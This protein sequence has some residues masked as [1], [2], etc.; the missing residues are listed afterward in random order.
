MATAARR[1]DPSLEDIL[2]D[3][4][5]EF[6]FFQ[7]VRLL[8]RVF[9]ERKPVGTTARPEEEVTR[10][11]SR[12]SMA[13]PPSAIHEIERRTADA[14]PA[15]VEVAFMGLTGVQGVMPLWYTEWL[16]ARKAAKDDAASD[17]FDLFNHRLLSLFFRAWKKHR[18]VVLYESSVIEGA[19]P[20]PFTNAL[21][22]FVGLAAEQLRGRLKIHDEALLRYCGLISQKPHSASALRGML[23]DY[24]MVPVEILQ[25][26]GSWYQIEDQDRC[27]LSSDLERNQLGV[28]AVVGEEIW[29]QQSRFCIRLGPLKFEE[30]KKFL[31]GAT[32]L[33]KLQEL[34]RFFVGKAM[35]FEVQVVLRADQVPACPLDDEHETAPR[36][37]WMAWLKT[38]NFKKDADDAVFT[39]VN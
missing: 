4:G 8:A 10:F 17:F 21:F 31:P 6:D 36:L 33:G 14:N 38:D 13:F 27:H 12:L 2:F 26:I 32:A 30:F 1:T 18:P 3:R 24:F 15:H 39:F 7:A 37:G 5:Y 20:D 25:G 34:T 19:E 9:P 35:P 23:R 11:H 29:N 28:G 22:A 16:L